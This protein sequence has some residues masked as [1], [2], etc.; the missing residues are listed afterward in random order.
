MKKDLSYIV[1]QIGSTRV[2]EFEDYPSAHEYYLWKICNP[3]IGGPWV[4]EYVYE[5]NG[6]VYV[7]TLAKNGTPVVKE[8]K[9]ICPLADY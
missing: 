1:Y 4:L 5:E 9:R 6:Y 7:Q 8:P 2:K 3:I